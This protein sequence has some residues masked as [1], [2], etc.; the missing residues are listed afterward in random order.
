MRRIIKNR[1]NDNSEYL[2]LLLNNMYK[3]YSEGNK[4]Y[5]F[6][7]SF[8][9]IIFSMFLFDI[10]EVE[11]QSLKFKYDQI[12]IIYPIII[13]ICYFIITIIL[14]HL[15]LIVIELKILENV[16]FTNYYKKMFISC[17]ELYCD[18]VLGYIM[19][20]SFANLKFIFYS[21]K[22]LVVFE[23]NVNHRMFKMI[24]ALMKIWIAIKN[25]ILFLLIIIF[26]LFLF[27]L[28]ISFAIFTLIGNYQMID[29]IYIIISLVVAGSIT[30]YSLLNMFYLIKEYILLYIDIAFRISFSVKNIK[31]NKIKKY[32]KLLNDANDIYKILS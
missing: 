11:I 31:S 1:I 21:F 4:I 28:P 18:G 15:R 26:S 7:L 2:D 29:D 20:L 32:L 12:I 9:F 3:K 19:T 8:S 27:L 23:K 5:I 17:P 13:A 30:V 14:S 6:C 10:N 24:I 25:S 16:R 22:K